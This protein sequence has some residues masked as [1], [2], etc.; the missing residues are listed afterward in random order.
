[1]MRK[2]RWLSSE[3]TKPDDGSDRRMT[4]QASSPDEVGVYVGVG[5]DVYVSVVKM[6]M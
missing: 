4:Y 6:C 2:K 3:E 5:E 1:M